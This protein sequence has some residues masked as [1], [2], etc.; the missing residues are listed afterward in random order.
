MAIIIDAE[1]VGGGSGAFPVEIF[2]GTS[3]NLVVADNKKFF[4]MDR[5]TTQTITIPENASEPFSI[6]AE[7]VFIRDGIGVVVFQTSGA[8]IL[9]SRDALVEINARY[10]VATLK[11]I[12]TDEWRLIGDLS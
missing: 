9:Q 11:K 5:T 4:V 2:T 1:N 8:A 3:K 6:G 10:S 7:M 12:N